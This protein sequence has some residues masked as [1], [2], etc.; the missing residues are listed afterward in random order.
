MEKREHLCVVGEI[1]N[2]TAT[3]ENHTKAPQNIKNRI[4]T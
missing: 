2:C 1:V 3:M 4:I